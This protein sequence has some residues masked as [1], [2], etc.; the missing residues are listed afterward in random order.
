MENLGFWDVTP[1]R[2]VAV[3]DVVVVFIFKVDIHRR[4]YFFEFCYT[5]TVYLVSVV[6]DTVV[7]LTMI[8]QLFVA[9][10][11]GCFREAAVHSG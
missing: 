3:T 2:L 11:C 1:C 10:R 6:S 5:M 7:Y 4:A 9:M 8:M